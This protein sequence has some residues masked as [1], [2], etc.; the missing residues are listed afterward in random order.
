MEPTPELLQKYP[1][2]KKFA[3]LG[4]DYVEW[5]DGRE[6]KLLQF[7]YNH[8]NLDQMRGNPLKVCEA[9]DDFAAQHDFLIN[10]GSDKGGK[11][12]KLIA[13]EKPEVFVELGGYI[14]Y[15]AILFAETMCRASAGAEARLFSLEFDPLFA[16]I[17][18]NLIDLAGLGDVVKVVTGAAAASLARLKVD[19]TL[20]C[21]D[22]LFLDHVEDLYAE[23]LKVCEDLGLLKSGSCIVADNV[24]RPGAPKYREY[25]RA[26]TG[27]TT[28]AI[29]GLI[30]PGDFED[31]IDV[32]K[33]K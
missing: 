4:D 9:I 18:M 19:G 3:E 21:I 12:C 26:H 7:I 1:S 10:I 5:K 25:V 31:E 8:P 29:K 33:M 24:L 13:E 30:V 20:D 16:S 15:S 11:V 2:L 6:V 28:R 14:G 27:L 32:S 17:A 23:D 22:M